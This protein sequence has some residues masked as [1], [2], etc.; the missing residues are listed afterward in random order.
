VP[1]PTGVATTTT[2]V[3]KSEDL[4]YPQKLIESLGRY[5]IHYHLPGDRD[6]VRFSNYWPCSRI[7]ADISAEQKPVQPTQ[8]PT[9]QHLLL[10]Q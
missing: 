7:G 2:E 9:P 4:G 6:C 1:G 8:R 10:R 5:Y 3:R